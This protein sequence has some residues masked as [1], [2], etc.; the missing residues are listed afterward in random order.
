MHMR[1]G[2]I[3]KQL[4]GLLLKLS[5]LYLEQ[6]FVTLNE[7]YVEQLFE[8]FKGSYIFIGSDN[9]AVVRR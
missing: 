5:S 4:E 7:W 8:K 2:V 1:L 3:A 9:K 6:W